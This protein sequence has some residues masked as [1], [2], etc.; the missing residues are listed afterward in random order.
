M[1]SI[2]GKAK[3]NG[4]EDILI[5]QG[6]MYGGAILTAYKSEGNKVSIDFLNRL[7]DLEEFV[8]KF[9]KNYGEKYRQEVNLVAELISLKLT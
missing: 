6:F 2:Q 9:V 1:V 7:Y 8:E 3:I 4:D 5:I